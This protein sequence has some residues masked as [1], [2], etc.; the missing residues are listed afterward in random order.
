M[1]NNVR[2]PKYKEGRPKDY[3]GPWSIG[4]SVVDGRKMFWERVTKWKSGCWNSNNR[5]TLLDLFSNVSKT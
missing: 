1:D 4:T 2:P 3:S 5:N